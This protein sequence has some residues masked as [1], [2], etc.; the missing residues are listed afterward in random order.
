GAAAGF[1]G[2]LAFVVGATLAAEAGTGASKDRQGL[3]IAI[4]FAGA[5]LGV[6]LSSTIV[7]LALAHGA[8][9]WR[10]GWLA[11]GAASLLACLVSLP[12]VRHRPALAPARTP[13]QAATKRVSLLPLSASYLLCGAG[14]IAYMT[15][16][17]A[18][19]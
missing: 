16:I 13:D 1:F 7:P 15:F 18:F 2:A 4:Y 6:A 8:T 10:W 5:G 14:Y 19:L 9:G 11:F 12:A 17:V 3:I